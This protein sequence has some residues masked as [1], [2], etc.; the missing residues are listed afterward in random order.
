MVDSLTVIGGGLAGSEAAWQAA[1]ND[2]PVKLYE[3]RPFMNTG[4]H[5]TSDLAELVCSNSLGSNMPDRASGLLK[6]EL[7]FLGSLLIECAD[8][9]ALPAGGALAVDRVKFAHFVTDYIDSH[10]QIEV[11]REEVKEI[12][13]E[14][15]II[16]S[17]PLTSNG[18]SESIVRL[19]GKENLYFFD[20][21]SPIVTLESVNFDIAY[22]GSR[23][24]RGTLEQGDYIN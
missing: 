2:I 20:A 10:P 19:T 9:T 15:V 22:M 18:L 6:N 1:Q 14:P 4:A 5:S 8:Q 16:A 24:G 11:I 12:P 17:G 7:R 23:Y 3:M 21:I 13:E